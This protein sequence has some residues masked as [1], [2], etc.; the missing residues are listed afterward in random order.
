MQDSGTANRGTEILQAV[1][2]QRHFEYFSTC[3]M[4]KATPSAFFCPK[5]ELEQAID[6][7]QGPQALR[8]F[9]PLD[10]PT[11]PLA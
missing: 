1:S 11:S 3:R 2:N 9:A 5:V 10:N 8:P 6:E 7:R 4:A